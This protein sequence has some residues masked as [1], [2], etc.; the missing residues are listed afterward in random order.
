MAR[1]LLAALGSQELAEVT[2][3][4][5]EHHGR[6]RAACEQ[7]PEHAQRIARTAF[8]DRV[9]EVPDGLLGEDREGL[10]HMGGPD[11]RAGPGKEGGLREL[12]AQRE[13]VG[14]HRLREQLDGVRLDA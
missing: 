10:A 1:E 11:A 14:T 6:R 13:Q 9:G 12:L 3:E 7:A 2:R 8:A 4:A 5:R